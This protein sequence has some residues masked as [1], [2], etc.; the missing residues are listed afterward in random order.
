MNFIDLNGFVI[1]QTEAEFQ[2][3]L[4]E[5]QTKQSSSRASAWTS[6]GPNF[7]S[8]PEG[9]S[10]STQ[11]NVYCID[12]SKSNSNVLYC[13]TE[14]G[15]VY[16]SI[17]GGNSWNCVSMGGY[18]GSGGSQIWGIGVSAVSIHPSNPDIVF[19]GGDGGVFR[20]IDGGN[21]WLKVLNQTSFGVNELLVHPTNGQLVFAATEKGLYRSIDGGDNWTQLY[22]QKSYDIKCNTA[23]TNEM[24]LVKNNPSL[25]ICEFFR[26]TD[27]GATWVNQTNGW[28]SSTAAGRTDGGAR[29][30]VTPADPNRVYAYLIGEAKTNDYGYIGVF[31]SNDGGQTWTLPNGPTGG[32]YT[33]SHP[34]L[35]YGYPAWTY[36]QG[37]Y[38]CALMASETNADHF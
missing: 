12:Q 36:H 18:F 17:D 7:V 4:Q 21:T 28:Y 2:N 19:V 35:A 23:N 34:N 29:I 22:A 9:T 14:P 11:S 27:F 1:H 24:Y 16:K 15:E 38:N 30:A 6:A 32:P 20:S 5:Y 33:A 13:G 31:R 26:S 8:G 25:I 3:K 37:F 10:G